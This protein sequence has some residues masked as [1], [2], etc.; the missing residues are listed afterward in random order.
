M[1][2]DGLYFVSKALGSLWQVSTLK[3][4]SPQSEHAAQVAIATLGC[5]AA[6]PRLLRAAR[7]S[8]LTEGSLSTLVFAACATAGKLRRDLL[9]LIGG[10]VAV[11]G[12]LCA[13]AT[14][15]P[16]LTAGLQLLFEHEYAAILIPDTAKPDTGFGTANLHSVAGALVQWQSIPPECFVRKLRTPAQSQLLEGLSGLMQAMLDARVES[17]EQVCRGTL[18]AEAVSYT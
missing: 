4:V 12:G 13:A 7:T 17:V 9:G 10:L 14:L 15:D 2:S 3:T 8:L 6:E 5:I 16:K 18:G 1:S 11:G